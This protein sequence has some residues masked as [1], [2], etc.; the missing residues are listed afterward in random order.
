MG[1]AYD[2]YY[3]KTMCID[4]DHYCQDYHSLFPSHYSHHIIAITLRLS[5]YCYHI[6]AITLLLSHYCYHII[7]AIAC[8]YRLSLSL[9]LIAIAYHYRYRLLPSL[10]A[11]AY[12]YR[13][14]LLPSL[15]AM[16]QCRCRSVSLSLIVAFLYEIILLS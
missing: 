3:F 16:A 5:H 14:R 9:S 6:I 11:I 12:H 8:C 2:G 4:F 13:Y 7:A 15:I 10:I 1:I